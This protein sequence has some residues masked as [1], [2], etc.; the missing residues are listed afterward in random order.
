MPNTALFLDKSFAER[1]LLSLLTTWSRLDNTMPGSQGAEHMISFAPQ[2]ALRQDTGEEVR[3][4]FWT[5]PVVLY[6]ASPF[7]SA[8]ALSSFDFCSLPIHASFRS[9]LSM[10]T[11]VAVHHLSRT[12]T[13]P[14]I[15]GTARTATPSLIPPLSFLACQPHDQGVLVMSALR[16]RWHRT[17]P[18]K[19]SWPAPGRASRS[20]IRRASGSRTRAGKRK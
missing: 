16:T 1:A 15:Q 4:L 2:P 8:S 9:T 3:S 20:M 7:P 6:A 19:P 17:P 13:R 12:F 10:A 14:A 18:K 5:D 11:D